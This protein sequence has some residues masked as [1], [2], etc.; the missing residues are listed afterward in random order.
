M[1][2]LNGNEKA[3]FWDSLQ[4]FMHRDGWTPN[5]NYG[6]ALE[7]FT[8]LIREHALQSLCGKGK[9]VFEGSTRRAALK[10]GI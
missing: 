7:M 10:R 6:Q 1:G 2:S 5:G 3:D 8:Q 4:V 9:W